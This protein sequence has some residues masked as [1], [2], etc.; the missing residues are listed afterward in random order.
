[1]ANDKLTP[2]TPR[3]ET[4]PQDTWRAANTL[5]EHHG[6]QAWFISAQRADA[7]LSQGDM[8]GRRAWMA[9]HRAVEELLRT[10]KRAGERAH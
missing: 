3:A 4:V 1:M 6:A 7:L 5:V 2:E 9:I 8:K 10:T